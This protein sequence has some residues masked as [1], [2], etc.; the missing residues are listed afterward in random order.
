M[1]PLEKLRKQE[2]K[3]L[4]KQRLEAKMVEKEMVKVTVKTVE[5]EVNWLKRE[6]YIEER[7][8]KSYI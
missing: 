7:N 8:S 4:P 5:K 1:M 6:N 2:K 3:R